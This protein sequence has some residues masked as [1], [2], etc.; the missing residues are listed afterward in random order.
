MTAPV[1]RYLKAARRA[2]TQRRYLSALEH[3]EGTWQG[4]LPASSE[5]V[6]RYLATYAEQLSSSTLHTHLAALAQ[7]HKRHGF[8]DPTKEPRVRDVLRGIRAEHPQP[9]K[10]AEALQLQALEDC[11]AGLHGQA[12]ST[13][14]A[15]RLRA[16]R[17][18]ALIL[19][20]FWR[21]FRSDDLCQ[22]RVE[23]IKVETGASLE[24]FLVSDK[25]DRDHQ[26]RT[27]MVPALKRLCPVAAY[28]AWLA[29]SGL[30][31]G[32]V[33]RAID[34]WGHVSAEGLNANSMSRLLRMAFARNGL[35]GEGYSGHSLRRG[36]ATWAN[37]NEW[38]AKALMD[39]VGWRDVHSAMRYID[40]TAPFGK[41]RR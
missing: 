1:D 20:G 12:T 25:T 31:Q 5:S 37:R 15:E 21:A 24:I 7:W 13:V 3:F 19:L 27:V 23:H 41:W 35:E 4:L 29:A 17:D 40:T 10:R 6:A 39:Y 30:Q 38:G 36:F 32:P 22:L 8:V 18:Q 11:V 9:V 26:G 14:A 28:E 34:R 16:C 2:S 33:F